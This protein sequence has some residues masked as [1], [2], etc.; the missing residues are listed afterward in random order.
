MRKSAS[1]INININVYT[2]VS[3]QLLCSLSQDMFT[4]TVPFELFLR[5][6]QLV[7]AVFMEAH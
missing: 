7:I 1:E 4:L 3:D 6:L 2:T 5:K